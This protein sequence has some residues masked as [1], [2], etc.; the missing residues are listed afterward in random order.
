[1]IKNIL[2]YAGIVLMFIGIMA[3]GII[4]DGG[5]WAFRALIVKIVIGE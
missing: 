3:I 5:V 2:F 1:M 4:V